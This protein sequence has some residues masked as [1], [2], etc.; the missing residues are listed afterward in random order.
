V[1]LGTSI[2]VEQVCSA[3]KMDLEQSTYKAITTSTACF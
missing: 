1:L 2:D 3:V